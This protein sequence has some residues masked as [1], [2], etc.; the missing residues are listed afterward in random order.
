[1]ARSGRRRD[2]EPGHASPRTRAPPRAVGRCGRQWRRRSGRRGSR[3]PS[4]R[5]EASPCWPSLGGTADALPRIPGDYLDTQGSPYALSSAA[6]CRY[7]ESNA[8][9]CPPPGLVFSRLRDS[10]SLS[11]APRRFSRNFVAGFSPQWRHPQS[12]ARLGHEGL[13]LLHCLLPRLRKSR[14]STRWSRN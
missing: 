9:W 3:A 11:C 2:T 14:P 1:M 5:L 4:D 10:R 13:L 6:R 7:R 12:A 8:F